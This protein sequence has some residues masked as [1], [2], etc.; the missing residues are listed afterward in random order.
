[1]RTH[2]R[3]YCGRAF[4]PPTDCCQPFFAYSRARL[5]DGEVKQRTGGKFN[6]KVDAAIALPSR[7]SLVMTTYAA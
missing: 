5:K 2:A 6:A 1:M 7:V 3:D 4:A